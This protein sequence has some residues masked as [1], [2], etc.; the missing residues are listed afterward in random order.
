MEMEVARLMNDFPYLVIREFC[1]YI[2]H[3][4]KEGQE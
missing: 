2:S 3:K 1:D 4:N